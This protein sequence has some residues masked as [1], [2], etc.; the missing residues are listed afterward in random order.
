MF[1]KTQYTII[2]ALFYML[3]IVSFFRHCE[4]LMSILIL[5]VTIYLLVSKKI[6]NVFAIVMVLFFIFG[7]FYTNF[8]M[9]DDDLLKSIA[10]AEVTVIGTVSSIPT[11]SYLDKTKFFLDVNYVRHYGDEYNTNSKVFVT[12][13]DE[14]ENYGKI[15]IG[16]KIEL[17]SRLRLPQSAT[18]PSQFNYAGY[19]KNFNTFTTMY[20][21]KSGWKILGEPV[22]LKWK[23]IQKLNIL[24]LNILKIHNQTIKTPNIEILGGIVF[25]DDAIS[26]PPEIKADF[27][28]SGLMHILAA[29]GLNVALIFGIWFFIFTCLKIPY[30]V[31]TI[32]G[33]FLIVLYTLMTGLGPPVLRASLMLT[34]A[35]LGKLINRDADNVALLML[36]ASL[37]L[38][39]NP[40]FLF[41]VGFQLS[42]SVTFGL[43]MFCP[44][45]ARKTEKIPQIIAGAI[46]VPLVAQVVV[47]PIQMY[48][49]NNFAVYSLFANIV[50]MPFVSVVSFLGFISSILSGL[51]FVPN[52]I[53]KIFDCLMDPV[54]T[55]LVLISKFFAGLPHSLLVTKQYSGV[56]VFIYYLLLIIVFFI[57]KKG[58]SKKLILLFCSISLILTVSLV[59]I[60]NKNLE[61]IF[62]NVGNADAI[63]VKTP[64]NKYSLIDTARPPYQGGFSLAKAVVYEY[65]KDKGIKALDYLIVTHYDADHAGG[66]IEIMKL[67][68]VKT[69]I[70]NPIDDGSEFF[71]DI[72][73]FAK[74]HGIN[75]IYPKSGDV[76]WSYLDGEVKVYQQTV[77]NK[78]SNESSLITVFSKNGRNILFS[79][80]AEIPAVEKLPL[81]ENIDVFK[82]GHHGAENTVSEKFL[83]DKNVKVAV[84]SSG[85]SAYG[86]PVPETVKAIQSSNALLLRTDVDNAI[87]AV[88]TSTKMNVYSFR[89]GKWVSSE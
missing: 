50:S 52:F 58:G 74:K 65:L 78:D 2:L 17:N 51:S 23:F 46:Y 55:V 40:A 84:L 11:A 54:L 72:P 62:F 33:I 68:K 6:S 13:V 82:V 26:P 20:V 8:K 9:K 32:L 89:K 4:F 22:E 63:L 5:I 15:K 28:H 3:G 69:V 80:D 41:D 21:T 45:L 14:H 66:A 81:P 70:L 67:V 57:L 19:L 29:S 36:V 87:K 48:Y 73:E 88:I 75:V 56:Q 35:L 42:F 64:D 34:F 31:G 49:F 83:N 44:I 1:T 60:P 77:K 43:L 7:D 10:P 47:A 25:G 76:L 16:D 12:I 71:V 85:P 18:N 61:A 24:R 39:Y 53:I 27:I 38:F 59:K 79:G 86:H 30:R 37:I